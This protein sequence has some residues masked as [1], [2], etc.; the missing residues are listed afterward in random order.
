MF[1]FVDKFN[2]VN[3][4]QCFKLPNKS[5]F[6]VPVFTCLLNVKKISPIHQKKTFFREREREKSPQDCVF[7]F[8]RSFVTTYF[9]VKT[10]ISIEASVMQ[11]REWQQ[12]RHHPSLYLSLLSYVIGNSPANCEQKNVFA[13]NPLVPEGIP[14][15]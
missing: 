12:S 7:P 10:F 5:P 14:K 9:C 8:Q 6:L 1:K 13:C 2:Q 15:P 11:F 4:S 3:F